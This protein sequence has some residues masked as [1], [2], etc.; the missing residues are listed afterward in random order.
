MSILIPI[1]LAAVLV[2][3]AIYRQKSLR[4][5][6]KGVSF[7][8][9]EALAI[10]K[11]VVASNE[12]I[13]VVSCG[14]NRDTELGA[15]FKASAKYNLTKS[16]TGDFKYFDYYVVAKT[17]KNIYFIPVKIAGTFTLVL[18]VNPKMNVE[19]YAIEQVKHEVVRQDLD[20]TMPSMD[21]KFTVDAATSHLVQFYDHFEELM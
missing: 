6:M 3:Y 20:A 7:Y 17:Q 13:I 18:K 15:M 10:A 16:S 11:T 12:E 4:K 2:I 1:I 9:E 21:I 8:G 19:T 5:K 14:T